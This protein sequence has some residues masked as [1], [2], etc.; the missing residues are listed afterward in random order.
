[1]RNVALYVLML[2]FLMTHEVD[3]AFRHE[4]RVL[5]ITSFLPDELGREIFIWAHV[6]LFAAILLASNNERVRIGLAVFSV[7]HVGLHWLFRNHP[8]YEFNNASSW[9]L[10]LGAG[11][12]GLGY[13]F[14]EWRAKR[15]GIESRD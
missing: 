6:P 12:L 11:A 4:W 13:L 15:N 7:I 3:A 14:A 9:G 1:M 10:I 8:A 5:P 2:S